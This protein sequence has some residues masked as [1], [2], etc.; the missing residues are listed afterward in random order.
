MWRPRKVSQ[1]T[2]GAKQNHAAVHQRRQGGKKEVRLPQRP[3]I[4]TIEKNGQVRKW[5]P[6]SQVNALRAGCYW[7]DM[8]GDAKVYLEKGRKRTEVAVE[9][10]V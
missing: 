3:T 8:R 7:E 9:M 2:T 4:V 6:L 1:G 5:G 10:T